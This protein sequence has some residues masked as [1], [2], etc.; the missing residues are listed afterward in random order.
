MGKRREERCG[1][2]EYPSS[3]SYKVGTLLQE[4]R[5]GE[6]NRVPLEQTSVQPYKK[7]GEIAI[8]NLIE[9]KGGKSNV[10]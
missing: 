1:E 3:A 6:K 10:A 5:K 2:K 8:R 9:R 4:R 7:G